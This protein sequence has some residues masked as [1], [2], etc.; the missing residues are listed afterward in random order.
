[1]TEDVVFTFNDAGNLFEHSYPGGM[2]IVNILAY[3]EKALTDANAQ[4]G[5]ALTSE[6]IEYLFRGFSGLGRNPTDVELMMFSQA[7]SEH[8][9]HKVFNAEWE[10]DGCVNFS[11]LFSMIKYTHQIN[12]QHTVL[13]YSDNSAIME[14]DVGEMFFPCADGIYKNNKTLIHVVM[15]VETHN[16]P[17]AISPYAGAATGVGGEIR[18]EGATGCGAKPKA[19][20]TG[21]AVS[22]LRIPGFIQPWEYGY[23]ASDSY[24]SPDWIASPLTIMLDAPIGGAGFNN[25]FGRPNLCGFFR[26]FEKMTDN[27]MWGFHKPVMLA[28]GIGCIIDQNAI[29][30]DC[31]DGALLVQIGGPGMLIGIGGGTASSMHAGKNTA[32]LDFASVQRANAE[33]ERRA[34]E[35]INRCCQ[36][37]EA[38]PI[39]SIHDV[40]AG[41]LSNAVSEFVYGAGRGG[42]VNLR[43]VMTEDPSMTPMQIWCNE[44][45]ERYVLAILPDL[46]NL[47]SE[48][49]ERERCPFSQIGVASSDMLLE[50]WDPLFKNHPVD[51]PL[52]I[53]FD[54]PPKMSRKAAHKSIPLGTL[55]LE[56]CTLRD[57]VYRVLK[58]PAVAD[59]TFLISIGDRTQGGLT[60]RDQ[61]VGPWQV[62]VSDVAVTLQDFKS[63]RGE[64]FAMGER[65]PIALVSP[66]AS[67]RMAVGEAITNI[68]AAKI[69]DISLIKLSA[70][71]MAAIE[72]PGQDAALFDTVYAVAVELCP[73][74]GISIPVGKDSMSMKT[75]WVDHMCENKEVVAPVSLVVTAFAVVSDVEKTLTPQ[76]RTDCGETVLILVDL[77][78]GKAR[79]GGSILAQAY[80]QVGDMAPDLDDALALKGFFTA[81]QVLNQ[82][83]KLLAY[84]DRSDGGLFVTLCEMMFAGHVGIN[85]NID[86]LY[87]DTH[88]NSKNIKRDDRRMRVLSLL[89]NE[90]LGAVIQVRKNDLSAV[91]DILMHIGHGVMACPIGILN[92]DDR[93][94]INNGSSLLLDEN[95][96][97][98]QRAWAETSYRIKVLRDNPECAKQEYDKILDAMDPGLNAVLTFTPSDDITTPF[99]RLHKPRIAILREQ[100]INGQVEMAAAFDRAN[101]LAVDVHMSDIISGRVRLDSFNGFAACGGFSYGDVLGAGG[102]WAKSILYNPQV[103]DEFEMFFSRPDSFA[104]GVCNGCQ[105]MSNLREIIPGAQNWPHFVMNRSEQF[106]ARLVMVE[107]AGGPSLFFNG[108]VG[109]RMPVV[110]SHGEGRVDFD[111]SQDLSDISRLVTMRYVDNRGSPTENYPENPNGSMDGITGL[112][113]PDGR[114]TIMM[115]HPDRSFRSVQHSWHPAN[116][117]EDGPWMRVFRNARKWME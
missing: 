95:R 74:L 100:G 94:K 71:W 104:L 111:S 85:V 9:R 113:T 27:E 17:T 32:C 69:D 36:M 117:T 93:L 16:H 79:L 13:A 62:P 41:G 110:C 106:E 96:V 109:S 55:N 31:P 24:G 38:N 105:M 92:Q 51:A 61:M 91:V 60:A 57:A 77:G 37:K 30:K 18:D 114:F 103:R 8:C 10:I 56:E 59:K 73:Q 81:I 116:W 107:I 90:E 43:S 78:S 67:G 63:M 82:N 86:G 68:A 40:G 64:A 2:N 28:G 4:M 26:T 58:V 89:F 11:S 87:P 23:D 66:A 47:F 72:H 84:H 6:E 20:L 65:A 108:M 42:K 3:G 5:L 33:M 98:L 45:Q 22:N 101:F 112:T 25:E 14:G 12:P 53:F 52:E 80:N 49:C 75:S 35:V 34:Q 83:K 115:P 39:L 102:G 48:I 97:D 21:F 54:N 7:N 46:L 1:M 70:N 99:I 76:L 50:I 44:A 88:Q 19:G 29:K 15:K